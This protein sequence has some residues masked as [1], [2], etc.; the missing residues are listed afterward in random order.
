MT[1]SRLVLRKFSEQDTEALFHI[2][3]DVEVNR[4]LPWYPIKSIDE[5]KNSMKNDMLL[6]MHSRKDMLMLS[7]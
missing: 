7:A 2:L 3:N 5:A 6:G 1:T 4:F